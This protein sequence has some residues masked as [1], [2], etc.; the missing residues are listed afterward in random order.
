MQIKPK[1]F[2]TSFLTISLNHDSNTLE[3]LL[4]LFA[5]VILAKCLQN[6]QY[7]FLLEN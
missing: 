4:Y 1:F 6:V 5:Y 2:Q 3:I 7:V